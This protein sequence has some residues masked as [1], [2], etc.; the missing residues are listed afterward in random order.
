MSVWCTWWWI[1]LFKFSSAQRLSWVRLKEFL[2]YAFEFL[3]LN[4]NSS[5]LVARGLSLYRRRC[6]WLNGNF[7]SES[8]HLSSWS[9]RRSLCAHHRTH[10]HDHHELARNGICIHSTLCVRRVLRN[11]HWIQRLSTLD[12]SV[13]SRW[14][15]GEKTIIRLFLKTCKIKFRVF[16][17]SKSCSK[18]LQ[19]DSKVQHCIQ[20]FIHKFKNQNLIQKTPK[21]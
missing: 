2:I 8:K 19:F 5:L 16:E 4:F 15:Y 13:W 3:S 7:H 20:K 14:I 6:C 1:W 9:F 17:N 11:W 10:S 12:W 18:G 21:N